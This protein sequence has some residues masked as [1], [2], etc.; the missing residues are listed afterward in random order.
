MQKLMA[1][2]LAAFSFIGSQARAQDNDTVTR[3]M[4]KKT[5]V[6]PVDVSTTRIHLSK[7]DYSSP[8]VK[9]LIPELADVTLLDHRNNQEGAPCMATYDTLSVEDVIQGRPAIEK[10]KFNITLTKVAWIDREANICRVSLEENL[11]AKIRGFNF[12]HSRSTE[13]PD[14]VVEDCR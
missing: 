2:T 8:V 10:V 5:V 11:Q 9:V 3:V 1:L 12:V 13:L 14:R 7:A 6:L 4:Q